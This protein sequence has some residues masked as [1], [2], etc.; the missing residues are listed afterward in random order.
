MGWP[1]GVSG[2]PS[3]RR[4]GSFSARAHLKRQLAK[5]YESD[6]EAEEGEQPIGAGARKLA[7]DLLAAVERRDQDAI[8]SLLK[9]VW[10]V[11]GKPKETVEHQGG[12]SITLS[13]ETSSLPRS[14]L[15]ACCLAKLVEY[16]V[17]RAHQELPPG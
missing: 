17:V 11:E 4:K 13:L 2:N 16:E 15:C 7:D 5:G 3:G 10:E 14:E 8:D 6:T 12:S 9:L 1:K